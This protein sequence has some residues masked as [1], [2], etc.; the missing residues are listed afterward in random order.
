MITYGKLA[1][2][3]TFGVNCTGNIQAL[4]LCLSSVLNAE[5]APRYIRVRMEGEFPSFNNFY[6]EQI[7][8]IAAHREVELSITYAKSEGVRR[9]RDWQVKMCQTFWLWMGDDDCIYR[10]DCLVEY[11]WAVDEAKRIH[12]VRTE[13]EHDFASIGYIN[14]SKPDINNR[15]GYGD[16]SVEPRMSGPLENGASMNQFYGPKR[17]LVRTKT[18]DTGNVLLNTAAIRGAG[19][20]FDVF[21]RSY[22]SGGEDTLMGLYLNSRKLYG[23]FCP[24]ARSLHLEKPQ[25][26]FGEFAA[27]GEML[28]RACSLLDIP[29]EDLPKEFMPFLKGPFSTKP[30]FNESDPISGPAQAAGTGTLQSDSAPR[31]RKKDAKARRSR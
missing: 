7:A 25:T 24:S 12:N 10:P 20:R 3:V 13:D 18:M 21:G 29:T 16:F 23:F 6:L 5:I 30:I 11:Q 4:L 14:G 27:R 15:R 2:T 22:N 17:V 8:A 1:D 28:L 19:L 31:S 26:Q 9:A